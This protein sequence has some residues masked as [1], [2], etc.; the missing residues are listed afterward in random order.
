M[1]FNRASSAIHYFRLC[2]LRLRL[3][4]RF[5]LNG[6][7]L[8]LSPTRQTIRHVFGHPVRTLQFRDHDWL[9]TLAAFE[10]VQ[11]VLRRVTKESCSGRSLMR[12]SICGVGDGMEIRASTLID[13]PQ[14]RKLDILHALR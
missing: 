6:V 14:T 13:G 4:F 8:S 3:H 5:R 2:Q 1:I 7:E 11:R 12:S 9:C 10:I